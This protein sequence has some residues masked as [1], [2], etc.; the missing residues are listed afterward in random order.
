MADINNVQAGWWDFIC[1]A[2]AEVW[3]AQV[4]A[5]RRKNPIAGYSALRGVGHHRRP[6]VDSIHPITA[7]L[8]VRGDLR[9][10][11]CC[12]DHFVLLMTGAASKAAI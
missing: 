3:G 2:V 1:P 10:P 6:T 4:D 11:P 9:R 12:G 5:I 8:E 7:D